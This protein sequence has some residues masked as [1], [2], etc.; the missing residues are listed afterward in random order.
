MPMPTDE[1]RAAIEGKRVTV[2]LGAG[3]TIAATAGSSIDLSWPG[4]LRD[5]ITHAES[6]AFLPAG[7]SSTAIDDLDMAVSGYPENYPI[8]AEKVVKALGGRTSPSFRR[9]LRE[10][11]SGI[12]VTNTDL[13]TAIARLH[14]PLTTTNFDGCVEKVTSRQASTWLEPSTVQATLQGEDDSIVHLHGFWRH[15]E[16][17]VFD[18]ES[19]GVISNSTAAEAV[20]KAFAV[21]KSFLFI[22]VGA[23]V[24]D[25]HFQSLM[26]WLHALLPDS[27]S[28]HY[29][30][31]DEGSLADARAQLST[32]NVIPICY[33]ARFEDLPGFLLELADYQPEVGALQVPAP[34]AQERA[35][36]AL[37]ERVREEALLAEC[38]PDASRLS[39]R[40][41]FIPP[42]ILPMV[43]EQFT[44]AM[45]QPPEQ[46]PRRIDIPADVSSG[47]ELLI[48]AA[49]GTGLTA[50]LEWYLDERHRQDA[51]ACPV[52]V[53][54]RSLG[55]GHRPL[56]KQIR[57][58]LLAAGAIARP[59]EELPL[60]AL[61]IDNISPRPQ[62]IINRVLDE[63]KEL[64]PSF[65]VLGC[66]LGSEGELLELFNHTGQRF[67]LR[68]LG[69]LNAGDI[70]RMVALVEPNRGRDLCMTIIH[71]SSTEHLLRTPLTIGLL[72]SVLLRGEQLLSTASET[73]LLD[74]YMDL[75][76]GRGDPHDDARFDLDSLERK[77]I[78]ASLAHKFVLEN[79][80]SLAESVVLAE[81]AAYFDNVGWTE[82]PLEV[83]NNL[84]RRRILKVRGGQVAFAQAS[85]LHLFAARRAIDDR[86]FRSHVL[87]RPLH[88]AP[89]IKH[90]AALTRNDSE[91]LRTIESLLTPGEE[92]PTA[93]SRSYALTSAS[94]A[95]IEGLLARIEVVDGEAEKEP[96]EDD[97]DA[98]LVDWL[99]RI[100]DSDGLPFPIEPIEEAPLIEQVMS[101]LALASNVL[102]DSE[103]VRDNE[104]KR[105]VL[106]KALI[107]WGRFVTLLEAD[108]TFQR[109]VRDMTDEVCS[110][111]S[112]SPT[113]QERIREEMID[114]APVFCAFAGMSL[115][116][117]TRKLLRPLNECFGSGLLE[118]GPAA[119]MGCL[120]GF[121]IQ[122]PGFSRYFAMVQERYTRVAAVTKVLRRIA[123]VAYYFQ[124]MTRE[125]EETLRDF[126]VDQTISVRSYRSEADRKSDRSNLLQSITRNRML[127]TRERLPAGESFY[128]GT[129]EISSEANVPAEGEPGLD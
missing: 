26:K 111:L 41:L 43:H 62:K 4:V 64:T 24:R 50:A 75:L 127:L 8:V 37:T 18:S 57:R 125:D 92:I 110:E 58:Q 46:R 98:D 87:A 95:T 25:P 115:T 77:D 91:I 49:E 51:A 99:D 48:A 129:N 72:L 55:P 44:S 105:N 126:V 2:V 96:E 21:A 31:C 11:F 118:D 100:G 14:L 23:G 80:G 97:D 128:A 63:L 119:I 106:F 93:D 60:C 76:L 38:L 123:L 108:E 30:L 7:W 33:G 66:R 107:V 56:E 78:L 32:T 101:A 102:R 117:S 53:D 122:E 89:I 83:L 28:L 12:E 15:P 40:E 19:Y 81:L 20:L 112:I 54:F 103:L 116:L 35:Y 61:A 52:L 39:I 94:V 82:D 114:E 113:K 42:V 34:S 29:L 27:E 10:R 109:M 59:D 6:H 73:A 79:T 68:Y 71:L 124:T 3:V 16:S 86:E 45:S 65:V 9:W 120:L 104:L 13:I 22:G 88:Y 1:L 74:A 85:Y 36:D 69:R 17:I 67:G 121:D 47:N 5:A 90:Y 84:L 70:D